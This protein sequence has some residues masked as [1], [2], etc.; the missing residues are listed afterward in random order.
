MRP[1]I[2]ASTRKLRVRASPKPGSDVPADGRG[3]RGARTGL[4]AM[5]MRIQISSPHMEIDDALKD[6]TERRFDPLIRHF[7]RDGADLHIVLES[8]A[9]ARKKRFVTCSARVNVPGQFLV[10]RKRGRDAYAAVDAAEQAL[11]REVEKFNEKVLIGTRFPKKQFV[12]NQVGAGQLPPL[13]AAGEAVFPGAPTGPSAPL[14]DRTSSREVD[15]DQAAGDETSDV[16]TLASA[17]DLV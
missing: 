8:P 15:A 1:V 17:S 14:T 2:G 13:V 12:A 11:Q 6:Y 4:S 9:G 3:F 7:D 10:A 5:V 16:D